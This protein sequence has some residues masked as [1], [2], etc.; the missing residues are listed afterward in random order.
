[1]NAIDT[2]EG[3]SFEGSLMDSTEESMTYEEILSNLLV[4]DE[5]VLTIPLDDVEH[6]KIGLKNLKSKRNK[7][8]REVGLVPDNATLEFCI[9]PSDEEDFVDLRIFH[10]RKGT[11]S[12]KK[13]FIPS[14]EF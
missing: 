9:S 2:D 14:G 4:S 6:V 5:L 1:M 3:D 7:R 8:L 12:V 10:I 13:M 11:V